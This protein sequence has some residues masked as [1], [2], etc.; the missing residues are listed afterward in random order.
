MNLIEFIRLIKKNIFLLI[1]I[2]LVM[3]SATY[4]FTRDADREYSSST[5]LYTGL[6]TGFNIESTG[7]SRK[8]RDV[9]NNSFENIINTIRSRETMKEV[10]F[11][12]LSEILILDKADGT[13]VNPK[14]FEKLKKWIPANIRSMVVVPNNAP[15]TYQK[16]MAIYESGQSKELQHFFNEEKT[17]F[18]LKNLSEIKANRKGSSDMIE[19][20]YS[21]NDKGLCENTLKTTLDVFMRRYKGLKASETGSVVAYFQEQFD[22]AKKDLSEAEDRMKNFRE[23]GQILNYYEQTKAIAGKKEDLTD[24][25][26]R[27]EG[28]LKAADQALAKLE[29]KLEIDRNSFFK[30]SE[31]LNQKNKISELTTIIARNNLDPNGENVQKLNEEVKGYEN[32]LTEGVKNLYARTHSTESI[33]IK[34]LLDSWLENMIL[35]EK[36]KARVGS[37]NIRLGEIKEDYARFA[38]LGSGLSRLER[39]IDVRERAY[40]QILHDLNTALLRKQNIEISS[41]LDIIDEPITVEMPSKKMML[42]ILSGIV[43]AIGVLATL[44]ILELSDR[45]I[46]NLERGIEFTGLNAA[47]ALPVF[48]QKNHSEAIKETL[49][50]QIVTNFKLKISAL[51]GSETTPLILITSTQ[52]NEGKSEVANL[53]TQHLQKSGARVLSIQPSSETRTSYVEGLLKYPATKALSEAKGIEDLISSW[54]DPNDYDY[55]LLEIPPFLTGNIPTNIL[56][57]AHLSLLV[58][59]ANRSWK[60]ADKKAVQILENYHIPVEMIVNGVAFDS[61][62][63]LVAENQTKDSKLKTM[64]KRLLRLEFKRKELKPSPIAVGNDSLAVDK[65]LKKKV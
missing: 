5:M 41:N 40:I 65:L 63:N 54:I 4:Y 38:P 26:H 47:G 59:S 24:E 13:H 23:N 64:I 56:K 10:S 39:E 61:L 25:H 45:T 43:G 16:L 15:A 20:T 35:V 34:N 55:C 33:Q 53:I 42:I 18:S 44:L 58:V 19:I 28:E 52:P 1:L 17:P 11:R 7:E 51:H 9:V 60:K 6:S 46:K 62:E 27:L 50:G 37:L 8:D 36:N 21:L 22:N 3:A 2:P 12:L 29:E 49:I 32:L 31:L 14:T 30:N 57:N 48:Y